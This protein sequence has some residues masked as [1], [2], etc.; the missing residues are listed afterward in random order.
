MVGVGGEYSARRITFAAVRASVFCCVRVISASMSATTSGSIMHTV[1]P[2]P[3]GRLLR[4]GVL[5]EYLLPI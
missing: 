3:S 4:F 1:R 5:S 2:R